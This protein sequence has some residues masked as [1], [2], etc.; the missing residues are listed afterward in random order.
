MAASVLGF[1]IN[2]TWSPNGEV[3][4]GGYNVYRASLSG[5]PYIKI[6]VALITDTS[7]LDNGLPNGTHFY[8]VTAEDALAN[9]SI[10]SLEV[11]VTLSGSDITT[12]PRGHWTFDEASGNMAADSSGNNNPGTL[13]NKA[14]Q[15]VLEVA[16]SGLIAQEQMGALQVEDGILEHGLTNY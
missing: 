13:L 9:E 1:S 11:N 3:N 6:N 8:V 14:G 5:G 16:F 15:A 4:L 12:G 7:Y 10:F 2:V